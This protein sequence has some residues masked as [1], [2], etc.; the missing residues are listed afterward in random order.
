MKEEIEVLN[1]EGYAENSEKN[2]MKLSGDK[3]INPE[4][5]SE[6][7][8]ESE[9][10]AK[11]D[12]ENVR[13]KINKSSSENMEETEKPKNKHLD[14]AELL[15]QVMEKKTSLDEKYE[16]LLELKD[17]GYK[18]EI[19]EVAYALMQWAADIKPFEGEREGFAEGKKKGIDRTGKA[20][21]FFQGVKMI[22]SIGGGQFDDIDAIAAK[23]MPEVE[24]IIGLDPCCRPSESKK[25]IVHWGQKWEDAK[26][27]PGS[28]G[29]VLIEA[30]NYL[31]LYEKREDK[32]EMVK[33]MIVAAG[34]GGKLL[35]TDEEF[36]P[37]LGRVED[38]VRNKL[39]NPLQKTYARMEEGGY[40]KIFEE[41]G[42]KI[43]GWDQYDRGSKIFM[44]EVTEDA[45]EKVK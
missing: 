44:L 11:Q 6:L 45:M 17:D 18:F 34:V 32:I 14:R 10:I 26:I 25:N 19:K 27:K 39:Y 30:S 1:Q 43:V 23:Y 31:Q 33:K 3:T 38:R 21:E 42:L 12:L 2:S 8:R 41:L 20:E 35:I 29:E 7:K 15:N 24:K 4:E 5:L 37:R 36:R 13:E 22:L 28:G 40:L 9:K 16:N